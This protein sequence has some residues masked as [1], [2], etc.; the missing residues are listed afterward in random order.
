MQIMPNNQP[1]SKFAAWIFGCALALGLICI[2]GFGGVY[3]YIWVPV[4][5]GLYGLTSAAMLYQSGSGR[6]LCWHPLF[7]PIL[8]FGGLVFLQWRLR[9]SL[10]P[11]TT[12]TGLLQLSG[13]ACMFYLMLFA[14]ES[15]GTRALRVWAWVL[16]LFTGLIST[17]AVF[18]FFSSHGFIYWFH[19]ASYATPI[20]P[21]VY[22]NHFAGCMDLLLPVSVAVAFR[23]ERSEDPVW[24]T[25]LRRALV[26][27]LGF[28]AVVISRSRGGII[29][30]FVEVALALMIFGGELR[31]KPAMAR[32]FW[33]SFASLAGFSVLANWHPVIGRFGKFA[34]HDPS[35]LDRLRVWHACWNIFLAHPL[36][37]TGFNT[38]ASVYPAYQNFDNGLIFLFAHNDYVQALAETGT[39]GMLCVVAFLTLW[40]LAGR[41]QWRRQDRNSGIRILQAAAWIGASGFL[42][43][44]F[45]DFQFHA[46][47]NALLFFMVAAMAVA[48]ATITN[49]IKIRHMTQQYRK[50]A[51]VD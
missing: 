45:G 21:Y 8:A 5:L 14:V 31:G 49:Y 3:V 27:A 51:A 22:H 28:A 46:P 38:F 44:S 37:G 23:Q 30:L 47:A 26:P 19:D 35:L 50:I 41:R 4:W 9:L 25:W 43:H 2:A 39:L 33:I 7:G 10:Y 32:T 29:T 6:R 20:G 36:W 1:G 11:G 12:L 34:S 24:I 13:C 42:F 48:P 17:E 18:Q 40:F 15:E 16:W